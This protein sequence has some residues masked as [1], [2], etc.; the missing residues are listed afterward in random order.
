MEDNNKIRIA[1]VQQ[2]TQ[3]KLD[4]IQKTVSRQI[5]HINSDIG[6]VKSQVGHNSEGTEDSQ[7]KE[8]INIK[9]ELEIL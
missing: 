3:E 4:K 8:L 7:H 9:E 2:E 5:E 1:T 6:Q